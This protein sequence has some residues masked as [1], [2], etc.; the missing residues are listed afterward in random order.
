MPAF[1]R[2][3]QR[4]SNFLYVSR[5]PSGFTRSR[6]KRF[7]QFIRASRVALHARRD[8]V[9]I[10]RLWRENQHEIRYAQALVSRIEPKMLKLF[11][12]RSPDM[13]SCELNTN[14]YSAY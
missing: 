13:S 9:H 12:S 14:A 5:M 8:T 10:E 6:P 4:S 3:S 2:V 11:I 1:G 7:L